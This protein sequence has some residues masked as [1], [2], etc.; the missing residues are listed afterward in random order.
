MNNSNEAINEEQ[1]V[2]LITDNSPENEST[3]DIPDSTN[4]GKVL[5]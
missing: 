1:S 3:N 5:N 4:T 2:E